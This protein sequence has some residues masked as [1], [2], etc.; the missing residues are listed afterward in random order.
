[1]KP[2]HRKGLR[3]P[4]L[5]STLIASLGVVSGLDLH[6]EDLTFSGTGTVRMLAS[7]WAA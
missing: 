4:F 3:N 7:D 1:M 5:A 2:I 6:A